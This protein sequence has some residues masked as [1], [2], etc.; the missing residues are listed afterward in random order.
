MLKIQEQQMKAYQSCERKITMLWLWAPCMVV[1][2]LNTVSRISDLP[3]FGS[4]FLV[5]R[6]VEGFILLHRIG[7]W[8]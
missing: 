8:V 5:S 6:K 2:G 3:R 4:L 7:R 1:G